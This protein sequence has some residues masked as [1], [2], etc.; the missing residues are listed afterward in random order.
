MAYLI[1]GYEKGIGQYFIQI[2]DTTLAGGMGQNPGLC[3]FAETCG[4][5]MI[6]EHNGDV[7]SCDHYV[8]PEYNL[9][10]VA[11]TTIREMAESP[12]QRKFGTDKR[13]TLPG[14]LSKM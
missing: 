10:N 1:S 9:G 14:V 3:I 4:D 5:A 8:Y 12:K 6:I 13:D 7:Y 2:F 11:D